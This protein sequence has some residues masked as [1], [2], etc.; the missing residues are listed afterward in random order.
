MISLLDDSGRVLKAIGNVFNVDRTME[1]EKAIADERLRMESLHGVYLAT[2]SFNVT[3]DTEATFNTGGGLSR[4]VKIDPAALAEARMA[5]PDIDRQQPETL[6]TLLS[7]AQQILDRQQRQEFIRCCSHEGMLRLFRNGQ[8]DVL[9]EY[10]RTVGGRPMWVS[11]RII[12]MAEPSTGDVLAFFYTRDISEQKESEQI[13]KLTMEKS[14]DYV[15]LLNVARRTLR[16]KSSSRDEEI[17]RDGWSLGI[18]NRYDENTPVAMN[19]FF[20]KE[21]LKRLS[22]QVTLENIV[23]N[24]ERLGEYSVTFDRT[25]LDG[26]M[27]RKQVQYHW[28]DETKA[29]I[30]I[31]QTDITAAYVQEQER[32]R[33]L[34][35]ALAA[36]EKANNAKTEFISRISHDIRT[37]ISAITS[38]TAFARED[39]DDREKLLHDLDRIEA[40][41]TLLLSLINDVLDISKID[42]GKIEL[43]PEPYLYDEY[44]ACIRSIFEPL[45][46]EHGQ[47]FHLVCSESSSGHGVLV[48]RIRYNQ[49]ALNLLSNAVKYTPAGGTVT[50]ASYAKKRDDGLIECSFEVSDTGIG[51][52]E[53][54]QKTMF[55]PF[56]QEYD[57][58]ERMKLSNGTGLG[59]SI[60]KRLVD[61]MNGSIAVKSELGK[62][63]RVTVG[64][65]LPDAPAEQPAAEDPDPDRSA[66]DN[67]LSGSVLLAEDNAINAEIAV[68]ILTAFG[69]QVVH[70]ENG[71]RAAE[72]FSAS[73]P[74]QYFAVLM[75]IQ[76]PVMNGYDATKAIRAL[77]RE[78]AKTVP[79]IAMTADAFEES[80]RMAKDAG[81]DD[82]IT[83][84]IEPQKLYSVLLNYAEK[85]KKPQERKK[86]D[87]HA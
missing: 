50:Y 72:L 64:F 80:V 40:S 85:Q 52:S 77:P 74:G 44:I 70:A 55:E 62:G 23:S 86:E 83:K 56:T 2:A 78:D 18:E 61:L 82:Y 76:M 43:H 36:A 15:A 79:V 38:M 60:V 59:L 30:L 42:S 21:K 48:D 22:E 24:L 57:N 7:A 35:E 66:A 26:E 84:P 9:L 68:R 14:Y 37:P 69:V 32:T 75:D 34:Q 5:E 31:V 87:E 8:R 27:H 20:S 41:N 33:Q 49:I 6:A 25:A 54:F 1:A 16:F 65:V 73:Q 12:L 13:A 53:E 58:P 67:A 51:M 81:I 17:L 11:T 39:A 45:C 28:L 19:R 47:I 3:K 10:R 4:S 71:R 29:E 63:T 46:R